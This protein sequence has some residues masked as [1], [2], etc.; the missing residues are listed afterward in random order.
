MKLNTAVRLLRLLNS[1]PQAA[2]TSSQIALKWFE[3]T[4][5]KINIRNIQR[6]LSEL[7]ADGADGPALVDVLDDER[8]RRY[9]LRLSQVA[10]WFMTE[11]AALNVLLTRQ[12]LE[13]SFS[14]GLDPDEAKRHVDMAEKVSGESVR[15]RRLRERLRIVPDG[16]GRLPASIDVAV[17][18][19]AVD[20]LGA[21]EQLSFSY[22]NVAGKQSRQVL[23]PH[24]LVAKD[25]TIYL[26]ATK[27]S[28]DIPH[29][30]A[31]HRMSDARV[32]PRPVQDRP[33]FDL[34]DYIEDSHQLSHRLD[35]QAPPIALQLRV[36]PKALF[37]F[38]ERPLS[39]DQQ[40]A[41][42]RS[43]DGW[44]LVSATVPETMLLLPF[45]LSLGPWIE[46]LAPASVRSQCTQWLR[47]ASA[48]YAP[49]HP[50]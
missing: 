14:A 15:T 32:V 22:A 18:A 8:E 47:Q 21:N 48:Y 2:L 5:A 35:G 11:Q 29:H 3:Q 10:Q 1:Q 45:L 28:S 41:P 50:T 27:G 39:A 20:A 7:S 34:D 46:V 43:A 17:L 31:L 49:D 33:D 16:I 4:G 37:H 25:G 38:A 19:S 13:R 30:F 26:L 24:G 12:L 42:P 40:I 6:Y 9:Y 36:A 23:S 44:H